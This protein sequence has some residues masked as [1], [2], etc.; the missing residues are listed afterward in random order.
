MDYRR[1]VVAQ[2]SAERRGAM[3]PTAQLPRMGHNRGAAAQWR[4][5]LADREWN[6]DLMQLAG[7]CAFGRQ[8]DLGPESLVVERCEQIEQASFGASELCSVRDERDVEWWTHGAGFLNA[9]VLLRQ[10]RYRIDSSR[11]MTTRVLRVMAD[12][13]ASARFG[14]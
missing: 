5:P 6:A 12:M 2:D 9:T 1:W 10:M 14:P 11:S 3:P 7:E 8:N 4:D 13:A